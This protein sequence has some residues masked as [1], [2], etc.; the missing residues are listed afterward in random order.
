MTFL[1]AAR[2]RSNC[3]NRSLTVAAQN[4][5]LRAARVSKRYALLLALILPIA[6][7]AEV[8]CALG[9]GANAYNPAADQRP[10]ADTMQV[11]RRVDALFVPFCLPKC[12]E[13]AMLRND[14][15]ANLMLTVDRDG[16]KLVYAPQFF[17]SVYGKYGEPALLALIAHVY[18]HAIDESVPSNWIPTAWDRE[19]RADAWAGCALAKSNLPAKD[20]AS[21]LAAL[22]AN[23]PRTGSAGPR[24]ESAWVKRAPSVKLGF[25]HCG[26]AGPQFDAASGAGLKP[27]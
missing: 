10:S 14:T 12:P 17:S 26:G 18:A 1:D 8:L 21:A 15:A 27:K 22:A 6:A 11:V 24:S 19:L 9:P 7:S 2:L 20:L 16:G 13:A 4:P 25:T 3:D 5:R 23:P